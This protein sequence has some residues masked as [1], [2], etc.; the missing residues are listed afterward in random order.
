MYAYKG[1]EF[2]LWEH[3]GNTYRI[4]AYST[5]L[6]WIYEILRRIFFRGKICGQIIDVKINFYNRELYGSLVWQNPD[7][8]HERTL[9]EVIEALNV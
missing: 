9:D 8:K 7:Y 2:I 4:L 6:K 5:F 3:D 1:W